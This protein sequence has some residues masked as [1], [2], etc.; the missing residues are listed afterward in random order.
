MVYVFFN[1]KTSGRGTKNENISRQELSEEL[2]KPIITN[3]R[4]EKYTHLYIMCH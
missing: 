3:L 1:Q 2:H 4:K